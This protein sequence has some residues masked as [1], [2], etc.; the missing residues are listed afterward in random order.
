MAIVC[1]R[2]SRLK[3]KIHQMSKRLAFL[4]IMG[5]K[6]GYRLST[7][8]PHC[9]DIEG[10][11]GW[12]SIRLQWWRETQVSWTDHCSF[13]LQTN[14]VCSNFEKKNQKKMTKKNRYI[15]RNELKE[16]TLSPY[17]H[18]GPGKIDT[19]VSTYIWCGICQFTR[20]S[21][22]TSKRSE[23]SYYYQSYM[24]CLVDIQ[25]NLKPLKKKEKIDTYFF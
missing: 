7:S 12:P 9:C 20:I 8:V 1:R 15:N 24:S 22:I 4:G 6:W 16:K 19:F 3:K 21:L 13:P 14:L 25:T 23:R 2:R 11:S 17:S 10:V 18:C 5:V